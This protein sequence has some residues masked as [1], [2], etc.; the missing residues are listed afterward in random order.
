MANKKC[1][2]HCKGEYDHLWWFPCWDCVCFTFLRSL[3]SRNDRFMTFIFGLE[4][5]WKHKPI[6]QTH[7]NFA[8]KKCKIVIWWFYCQESIA[9]AVLALLIHNNIIY[10]FNLH[11][12]FII[13]FMPFVCV[14]IVSLHWVNNAMQLRIDVV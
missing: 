8:K 13:D 14:I 1:A 9:G 2:F 10:L 12:R 6:E 7:K 5:S 4:S 11:N 3:H